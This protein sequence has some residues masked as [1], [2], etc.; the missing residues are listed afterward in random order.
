MQRQQNILGPSLCLVNKKVLHCLSLQTIIHDALA[1]THDF[2]GS[3]VWSVVLGTPNYKAWWNSNWVCR[4][5][6]HSSLMPF[7]IDK[8]RTRNTKPSITCVR[9][10]FILLVTG[11]ETWYLFGQASKRSLGMDTWSIQ[12]QAPSIVNASMF[13]VFSLSR[14]ST[15]LILSCGIS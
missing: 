15:A 10:N 5:V 14:K 9:L 1:A 13:Y 4:E 11:W 12:D 8:F 6:G 3:C 7:I 2:M